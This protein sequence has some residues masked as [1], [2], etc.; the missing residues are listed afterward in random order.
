MIRKHFLR[1]MV[2]AS[3]CV[4][5]PAQSQSSEDPFARFRDVFTLIRDNYV[6]PLDMAALAGAAIDTIRGKA[7]LDD[8]AWSRCVGKKSSPGPGEV[9]KAMR[10]AGFGER[11]PETDTVIDAAIEAMVAKL[12]TH[13]R[14][15]TFEPL[16]KPFGQ[17]AAWASAGVTLREDNRH[18]M[19][20]STGATSAAGRAGIRKGDDLIAIDGTVTAELPFDDVIQKLRGPVGSPVTLTIRRSDGSIAEFLLNRTIV[21]QSDMELHIERRGSVLIIRL[22]GLSSGVARTISSALLSQNGEVSALVLDLQDNQGGLLAETVA[23]A[24]LFLD[25]GAIVTSKGREKRDLETYWAVKGQFAQG[26]PI[27][28]LVNE[29]TAA[30]AEILAAALQDHKRAIVFGRKTLGA[31]S[32]QTIIPVGSRRAL[33]LTTSQ[34]YRA[35]GQKLSDAPVVPNCPSNLDA[36]ALLDRLVINAAIQPASCPASNQAQ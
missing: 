10:C 32:V 8:D 3:L 26:I 22:S 31:G 35:D 4:A 2:T 23:I 21:H 17:P 25:G 20:V 7:A 27:L 11:G 29:N 30:G 6:E 16:A 36:S 12:D 34:E 15:V 14:W 33:R 24:D 13:S 28:V 1:A 9:T 18:Y 19:V 5:L